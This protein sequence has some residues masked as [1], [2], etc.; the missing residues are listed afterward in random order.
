MIDIA[1]KKV[2]PFHGIF[3]NVLRLF[4]Q[5][6]AVLLVNCD[7]CVS[8]CVLLLG[9]KGIS[10]KT[11]IWCDFRSA[12]LTE[13]KKAARFPLAT[14]SYLFITLH[15]VDTSVWFGLGTQ[16]GNSFSW[17][18]A[19]LQKTKTPSNPETGVLFRSVSQFGFSGSHWWCF[20]HSKAEG[21]VQAGQWKGVSLSFLSTS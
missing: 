16:L 2:L 14:L 12:V 13:E 19:I 20:S 7:I 3:L 9:I 21:R 5:K 17:Q 1:G 8:S 6:A 11:A 18:A 15:V 4:F 10:I